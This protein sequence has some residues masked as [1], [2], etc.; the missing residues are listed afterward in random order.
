MFRSPK[1]TFRFLALHHYFW[2]AS[3]QS[4]ALF[5]L[6][7]GSTDKFD[8]IRMY[9][10]G[11]AIDQDEMIL[12]LHTGGGSAKTTSLSRTKSIDE[13]ETEDRYIR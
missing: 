4:V 11:R 9:W 6:E 10:L 8:Y 5:R 12:T 1:K 3:A 2:L 7:T 13:E